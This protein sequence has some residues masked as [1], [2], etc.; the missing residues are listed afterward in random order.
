MFKKFTIIRIFIIAWVVPTCIFLNEILLTVMRAVT[1]VTI[2]TE[3]IYRDLLQ[4][5]V[6]ITNTPPYFV[7]GQPLSIIPRGR[8]RLEDT[9][10]GTSGGIVLK[11]KDQNF[12]LC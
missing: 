11:V 2:V 4:P 3:I 8:L 5:V 9:V 12:S 7:T 1:L 10:H 6:L